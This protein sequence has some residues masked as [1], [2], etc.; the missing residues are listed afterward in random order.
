MSTFQT[1]VMSIAVIFLII[2]LIFVGI[3]LYRNKYTNTE[4]PP[5]VPMCP[6]FWYDESDKKNGSKCVNKLNLGDSQCPKTMDFSGSM[7]SGDAGNCK[8]VTWAKSCDVT[9]DGLENNSSLKCT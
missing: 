4:F 1:T 3:A 8:K 7:W 9:W 2:C 5:V 6:D